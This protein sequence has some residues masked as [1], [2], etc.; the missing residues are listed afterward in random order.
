MG[1]Q[2]LWDKVWPKGIPR[3]IKIEKPYTEY[4]TE[5]A[6]QQPDAVAIEYNGRKISYGE[7]EKLIDRFTWA[8]IDMGLRKGERVAL[9]L[10]NCPQSVISFFGVHRAGGVVVNLNPMNKAIELKPILENVGA[11]II[12]AIDSLYPELLKLKKELDLGTVILTRLSDFMPENTALNLP[13]EPRIEKISYLNTFDFLSLLDRPD[14]KHICRIEDM[15]ND[16]ALLQLTGGTTG[17]PRAAMLSMHAFTVAVSG[18]PL[19]Y[20]LTNSDI[21][22]GVTPFFHIMGLQ[23]T[24][25]PALISG[26][27]LVILSRFTPDAAA[28]AITRFKCSV[29]VAAPTMLTSLINLK[30]IENYDFSSLRVI[31][32]GGAPVSLKLQQDMKKLAPN[33]NLGE[34]YGMTETLAGGGVTT[35]IGRWKPGFVGIPQIN[36]IKIVDLKTGSNEMP[37]NKEGE[38]IIKGPTVMKGYWNSPEETRNALKDGWFYTGDIG[39]MDEEG[40]LKIVDRKKEL[41]LCSGYN[42]YP[43]DVENIMHKHPAIYEVAVVGVPDEYRGESP[44]AFITLKEEYKGKITDHEIIDWCKENMSSY[45]RPRHVKFV[46]TLPKSGAGKILKRALK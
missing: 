23:I 29:W 39:L 18:I 21:H 32:T 37:P 11:K 2:R 41:I 19:W 35:P 34:G 28:Q 33:A 31:I 7:L 10:Q 44:K 6:E 42:V 25:V 20:S 46:D 24:M 22:F 3:T 4:L 43:S 26:G 15:E 40:Y 8:L 13:S 36:D 1:D 17:A 38:I 27:K 16:L 5:Q 14:R 9:Y 12:I 45:K 30:N